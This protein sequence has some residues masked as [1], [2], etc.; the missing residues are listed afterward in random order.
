MANEQESDKEQATR[1]IILVETQ[2]GELRRLVALY[3]K[4]GK[5]IEPLDIGGAR[6]KFAEWR[7][8][9]AALLSQTI[10]PNVGQEFERRVDRAAGFA[11]S[12]E[13][14]LLEQVDMAQQILEA[15]RGR[16]RY[17]AEDVLSG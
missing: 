7:S 4:P 8:R 12:P 1:A 13:L 10:R 2:L 15:L 17:H 3:I 14:E 11:R 6:T 9:T 5:N 16:L